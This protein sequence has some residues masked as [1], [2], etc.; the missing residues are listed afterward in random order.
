MDSRR[1]MVSD[2]AGIYAPG[3]WLFFIRQ[4]TL[5]AR[6]FDSSRGE[7]EGEPVTVADSV[8]L[9]GI[10]SIGAVSVSATGLLAYRTGAAA[11]SQLLWFD[12][13]GKELG[14]FGR[15]DE[16]EMYNPELSP[17]GSESSCASVAAKQS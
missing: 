16:N 2:S 5:M 13:S 9:D 3:G 8:G 1:L 11:T 6:R 10:S 14:K 4:T 7:F 12:R 17:D 15:V